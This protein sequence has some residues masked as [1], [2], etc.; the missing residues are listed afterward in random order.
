M[1][2]S[3]EEHEN[4]TIFY[5]ELGSIIL[6]PV[7]IFA[8]CILLYAT[9]SIIIEEGLTTSNGRW[10]TILNIFLASST[11]YFYFVSRTQIIIDWRREEIVKKGLLKYT[12]LAKFD[13]I[14]EINRISQLKLKSYNLILKSDRIGEGIALIK[15]QR[16]KSKTNKKAIKVLTQLNRYISAEPSIGNQVATSC[17]VELDRN[18]YLYK[19][20]NW[21]SLFLGLLLLTISIYGS[22]SFQFSSIWSY[23]AIPLVLLFF[24][25]AISMLKDSQ[26]EIRINL[27][28]KELVRTTWFGIYSRKISFENINSILG[29]KAYSRP[30]DV[31]VIYEYAG[32]LVHIILNNPVDKKTC[33]VPFSKSQSQEASFFISDLEILLQKPIL[34][35]DKFKEESQVL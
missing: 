26:I 13:E 6:V 16:R 28:N 21:T 15:H 17:F 3:I 35:N 30:H 32:S 24:A 5:P 29:E 12:F 27:S 34:I 31:N 23:G 25:F 10:A 33:S 18:V 14:A 19:R 8:E 9:A 1:Y 7:L 11:S 2:R 4:R 20:T 22:F